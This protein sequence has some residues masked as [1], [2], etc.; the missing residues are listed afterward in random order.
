MPT[1]FWGWGMKGL[2]NR[3]PAWARFWKCTTSPIT[4]S[5][6]VFTLNRALPRA[7]HYTFHKGGFVFWFTNSGDRFAY[8]KDYV[9]TSTFTFDVNIELVFLSVRI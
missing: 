2:K 6:Q 1:P 7:L 9:S 4:Q 8:L 5:E 3:T